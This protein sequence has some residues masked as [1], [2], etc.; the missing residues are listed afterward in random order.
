MN[1]GGVFGK[2]RRSLLC[3]CTT[4]G[5]KNPAEINPAGFSFWRRPID[6]QTPVCSPATLAGLTVYLARSRGSVLGSS[7]RR[8]NKTP[9]TSRHAGRSVLATSYSRTAYRRTTIGAA[10]FHCRVRNGNGWGHC[11]TVTRVRNRTGPFRCFRSDAS[12]RPN[13]WSHDDLT[14][15]KEPADSLISTYRKRKHKALRLRFV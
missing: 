2:V 11:A 7:R 14:I 8:Q 4:D 6:S 12:A 13:L 9:S 5:S 10:A 1:P 15:S 3:G